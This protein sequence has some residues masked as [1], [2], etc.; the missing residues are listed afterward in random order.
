MLKCTLFKPCAQVKWS[1]YLLH[2]VKEQINDVLH[3]NIKQLE[4]S[5]V[6]ISLEIEV[7]MKKVETMPSQLSLITGDYPI[8][9]A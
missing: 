8:P 6:L 3:V 5:I 9:T 2:E 7:H 1:Q 4:A